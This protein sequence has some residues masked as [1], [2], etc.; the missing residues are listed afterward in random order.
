MMKCLGIML[1]AALLAVVPGYGDAQSP[2]T[3]GTSMATQPESVK[4]DPEQAGKSFTSKE[5]AEY[6]TKI[7]A[8]LMV[9][10]NKID[11]LKVKSK[12]IAQQKKHMYL[13]VLID[14]QRK[15]VDAQNKLEALKNAPEKDWSAI[16]DDLEMDMGELVKACT[17]AE[18]HLK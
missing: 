18:A 4:G 6:Q 8:D 1:M 14:L 16:R 5:K 12:A 2:V 10:E 11:T 15:T 7:A 9:V 3:P 13:R 17:A